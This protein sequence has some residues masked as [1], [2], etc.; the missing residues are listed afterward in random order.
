MTLL[1]RVIFFIYFLKYSNSKLSI[2]QT[3]LKTSQTNL[4]QVKSKK[5]V[6]NYGEVHTNKHNLFAKNAELLT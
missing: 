3:N 4:N 1:N 5:R 2:S 6:K